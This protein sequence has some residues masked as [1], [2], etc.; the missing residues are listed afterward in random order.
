MVVQLI[1]RS[2][3]VVGVCVADTG[4]WVRGVGVTFVRRYSVCEMDMEL[5]TESDSGFVVE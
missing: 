2:V 3:S 1:Y 4:V 5:D